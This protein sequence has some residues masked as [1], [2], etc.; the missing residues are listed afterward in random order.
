MECEF[1]KEIKLLVRDAARQGPSPE[2]RA[3]WPCRRHA[4]KARIIYLS[5]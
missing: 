4:Q 3:S 1:L 5:L 2:G